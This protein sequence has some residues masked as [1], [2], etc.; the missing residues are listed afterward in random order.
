ML[1]GLGGPAPRRTRA[2]SLT[3]REEEVLALVSH[4]LG[5]PQIAERLYIS[6]KTA[7]HVSNVLAKLGVQ[8]RA[9]AA[10]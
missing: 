2:G 8:D 1:R 10:A 7:S 6:R 3:D 5:N 4:G 9:E